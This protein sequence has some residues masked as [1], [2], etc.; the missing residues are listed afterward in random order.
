MMSPKDIW[1]TTAEQSEMRRRALCDYQDQPVA[2]IVPAEIM[3]GVLSS[4]DALYNDFFRFLI[5]KFVL[6]DFKEN[7][8]G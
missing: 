7:P 8:Y 1:K 5:P 4:G 2:C 3:A 6:V